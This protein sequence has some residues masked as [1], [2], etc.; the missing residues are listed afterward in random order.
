L[1][2]RGIELGAGLLLQLVRPGNAA[3]SLLASSS[4]STCISSDDGPS[5][6]YSSQPVHAPHHRY[7][8]T[9]LAVESNQYQ[10]VI[11]QLNAIETK[12]RKE[13]YADGKLRLKFSEDSLP[14]P[15]PAHDVEPDLHTIDVHVR[16]E[17]GTGGIF[18]KWLRR[19]G[20]TPARV[21]SI[22]TGNKQL[23]VHMSTQD[24]DKLVRVYGRHGCEARVL[25]LRVLSSSD[26]SKV[27]GM[28][29]VKPQRVHMT[30]N[31]TGV[32]ENVDLLFCPRDRIVHV[33]V[34][35][36]L[37]NDELAPGVKKGGW[38]HIT[39]R[40]VRYQAR[41]CSIPSAIEVD[42][43]SLEVGQDVRI[44]QLPI[45][46][47]TRLPHQDYDAVVVRCTTDVGND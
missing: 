45:P 10:A 38:M 28:I 26:P 9:S 20:R 35:I 44:R 17:D 40:T 1:A 23:L 13:S 29:R 5:T 16:P 30:S 4:R 12:L 32:V 21:Q 19:T 47:N 37:V 46:P 14:F 41:G 7:S 43:K 27:L 3:I 8:T 36:K 22:T 34:P 24:A 42:V 6:S 18:C 31:R 33:N 11:S 39:S 25:A 15:I 2:K